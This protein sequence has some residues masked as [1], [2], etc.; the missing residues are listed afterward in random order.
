MAG[1]LLDLLPGVFGQRSAEQQL[2][3]LSNQQQTQNRQAIGLNPDGTPGGGTLPANQ[4]PNA[5]KT[6]ESW[7]SLLMK[8]QQSQAA[9]QLF[10]QGTGAIAAGFAQPRDREMVSKIFNVNQPD[11][12]ATVNA[13][14][15]AGSN[16]QGQDRVNALGQTIMNPQTGQ[17]IADRLNIS[18]AELQARFQADPAGV[19]HMIEGFASPTEQMKNLQQIKYWSDIVSRQPGVGKG[20]L[21]DLSKAIAN[22]VAGQDAAPMISAQAAWRANPAHAGKP[23]PWTENDLNSFKQYTTN[24]AAKEDDR[25]KASAI[26][27]SADTTMRELYGHIENLQHNNGL[28]S[29]LNGTQQV[30]TAAREAMNNPDSGWANAARIAHVLTEPQIAAI[31][32]L[33][34]VNSGQYAA[35]L[36]SLRGITSRPAAVEA[37]GVADSMGQTK[38]IDMTGN[39]YIK[40]AIEPLLVKIKSARANAWGATGNVKNMDPELAPYM[41]ENYLPNGDQYKEGSGVE[42]F[43]I[44]QPL[45][46]DAR[47][48]AI[49]RM[50]SDY[51]EKE[52][53][54]DD[55]RQ[56]GFDVRELERL[57]PEKL[58]KM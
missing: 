28:M 24:E 37:Q 54:I 57:T 34:Q 20:D 8:L 12:I 39:Q 56:K 51:T 15:Q 43:K 53:T 11:P 25:G 19:G 27:G 23:I 18:L 38:A 4:E 41:H 50:K 40:Q 6:P 44:N 2:E 30:K 48:E 58:R 45:P 1:S 31:D 35:A 7:G 52:R 26:L 3:D 10:N 49:A 14:Q 36:T 46:D 22:G 42:N 13:M 32:E 33:R 9:D 16:Q 21:D 5:T 17:P 47:A 29:I 55:L